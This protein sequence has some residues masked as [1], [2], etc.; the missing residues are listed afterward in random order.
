MKVLNLSQYAGLRA[1]RKQ[2][3]TIYER[4]LIYIF[5]IFNVCLPFF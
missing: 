4:E 1:F 2:A 3:Q 5:F